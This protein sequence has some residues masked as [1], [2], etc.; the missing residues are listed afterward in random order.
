MWLPIRI[1]SM[2]TGKHDSNTLNSVSFEGYD[3]RFN[4]SDDTVKNEGV[5]QRLGGEFSAHFDDDD[6][7]QAV[8]S[9]AL[10]RRVAILDWL[11]SILYPRS[12]LQGL[13]PGS[14]FFFRKRSSLQKIEKAS[15]R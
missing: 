14:K 4:M 15:R 5:H 7:S 11:D 6:L 3:Y 13:W 9:M 1:L 10:C 2:C 8:K 12:G